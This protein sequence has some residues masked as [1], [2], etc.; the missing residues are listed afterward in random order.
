MNVARW[1]TFICNHVFTLHSAPDGWQTLVATD[2][3][4]SPSDKDTGLNLLCT[5]LSNLALGQHHSFGIELPLQK[6]NDLLWSSTFWFASATLQPHKGLHLALSRVLTLDLPCCCS[7]QSRAPAP[8]TTPD[9]AL[10]SHF[11]PSIPCQQPVST[12][13]R[14]TRA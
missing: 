2:Q 4:T 1:A 7:P 10:S 9:E 8:G 11:L 3:L 5:F 12:Y 6:L 13:R 14:P